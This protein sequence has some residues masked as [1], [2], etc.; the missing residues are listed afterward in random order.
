MSGAIA[1]PQTTPRP[2]ASTL[3]AE[4]ARIAANVH[5]AADLSVVGAFFDR[6][7]SALA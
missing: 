3:K 1:V 4:Q 5:P 6:V 2:D 7:A